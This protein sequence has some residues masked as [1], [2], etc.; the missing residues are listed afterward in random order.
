IAFILPSRLSILNVAKSFSEKPE[1]PICL[2]TFHTKYVEIKSN[3]QHQDRSYVIRPPIIVF[4]IFVSNSSSG[5]FIV[6]GLREKTVI[7]AYLPL[8]M[9][10]LIVSSFVAYAP[11]FVNKRKASS[12]VN[13]CSG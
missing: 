4:S 1:N 12:I 6:N 3:K 8:E 5:S 10:P 9:V 13:F 2:T 7:S 11:I